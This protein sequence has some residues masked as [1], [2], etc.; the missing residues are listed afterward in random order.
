MKLVTASVLAETIVTCTV[1]NFLVIGL[2]IFS[3]ALKIS[4][5]TK[6]STIV[7]AFKCGIAF[8]TVSPSLDS[9]SSSSEATTAGY[10]VVL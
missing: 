8:P 4:R 9:V 3:I 6:N 2:V 7:I 1:C 10:T 5:H